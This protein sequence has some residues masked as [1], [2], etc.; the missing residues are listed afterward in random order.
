MFITPASNVFVP[1]FVKRT[2]V[3]AP[4]KATEPFEKTMEIV[5]P[6]PE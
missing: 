4:D 6:Y 1:L 2:A 3:K 5:L